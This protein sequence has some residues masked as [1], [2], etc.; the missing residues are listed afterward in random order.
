M[1]WVVAIARTWFSALA[2]GSVDVG[3]DGDQTHQHVSQ[4]ATKKL[5]ELTK[6]ISSTDIES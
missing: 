1:T 6:P 3:L 5:E 2:A 4:R